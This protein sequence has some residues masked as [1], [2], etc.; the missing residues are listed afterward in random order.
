MILFIIFFNFVKSIGKQNINALS[1]VSS[2]HQYIRSLNKYCKL[3]L[4]SQKEL[5]WVHFVEPTVFLDT[6]INKNLW[7]KHHH[8][9]LC[10]TILF[11]YYKTE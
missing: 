8:A 10:K 4:Y 9:L 7:F 6:P 2:K 11:F 5:N 1:E 3:D